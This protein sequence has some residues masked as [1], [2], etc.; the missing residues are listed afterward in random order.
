MNKVDDENVE[1]RQ[2][3]ARLE[4]SEVKL[5]IR[6]WQLIVEVFAQLFILLF[7]LSFSFVR[8]LSFFFLTHSA[9]LVL[10]VEHIKF[11]L[12]FPVKYLYKI[13]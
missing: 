6:V 4:G 3:E 9:F 1:G 8:S 5:A 13:G 11:T 7:A 12:C 10:I 2:G